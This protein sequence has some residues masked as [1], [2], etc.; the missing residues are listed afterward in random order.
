MDRY[1][2]G[3][4]CVRSLQIGWGCLTDV[5][6]LVVDGARLYV[7]DKSSPC[8]LCFSSRAGDLLCEFS[9]PQKPSALCLDQT[10]SALFCLARDP[11]TGLHRLQAFPQT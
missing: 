2:D 8:V 7:L 3:E 1:D 9:F 5:L 4:P 10:T 6:S 11:T